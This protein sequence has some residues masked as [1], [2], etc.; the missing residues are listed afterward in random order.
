MGRL[1]AKVPALC[2]RRPSR[3][4]P[5][6]SRPRCWSVT[7][8][9]APANGRCGRHERVADL[10]GRHRRVKGHWSRNF[11]TGPFVVLSVQRHHAGS[12]TWADEIMN[13]DQFNNGVSGANRRFS[14]VRR[15][16]VF[17]AAEVEESYTRAAQRCDCGILCRRDIRRPLQR[18][19]VSSIMVLLVVMVWKSIFIPFAAFRTLV[20][21]ML[22]VPAVDP[23]SAPVPTIEYGCGS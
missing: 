9:R 3:P 21:P 7:S 1:F 18:W 13:T 17:V 6:A 12:D 2:Q 4:A 20:R 22:A 8:A 11:W 15:N 16:E 10:T 14:V 5:P 23:A 19:A